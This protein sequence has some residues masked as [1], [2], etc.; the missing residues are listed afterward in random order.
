MRGPVLGEREGSRG[1]YHVKRCPLLHEGR[2]AVRER[3]A[4]YTG[5][6]RRPSSDLGLGAAEHWAAE[7]QSVS[8]NITGT[9]ATRIQAF[10]ERLIDGEARDAVRTEVRWVSGEHDSA[11]AGAAAAGQLGLPHELSLLSRA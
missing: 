10:Q 6:M 8:C 4:S 7:R 1:A 5:S 11:G 2:S 9:Y 3:A